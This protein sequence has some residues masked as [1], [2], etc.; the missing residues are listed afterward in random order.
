RDNR[1]DTNLAQFG[2]Q[3]SLR[4]AVQQANATDGTDTIKFVSSAVHMLTRSGQDDTAVL[5]DL[6][7]TEAVTIEGHSPATTIDANGIDRVFDVKA[8]ANFRDLI[9]RGGRLTAATS[10]GAV[11]AGVQGKLGD[12]NF[13][14]VTLTD[15]EIQQP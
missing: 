10:A 7:I 12:L 3:C 9:I 13:D 6:D 2:E 5:G 15:N 1:C 14:H 4:A 8:S 11:S